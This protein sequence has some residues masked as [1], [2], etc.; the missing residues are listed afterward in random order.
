[1]FPDPQKSSAIRDALAELLLDVLKKGAAVEN[2]EGELVRVT[3]P[4]SYLAVAKDYIKSFPP[5][6]IPTT[7]SPTGELGAFAAKFKEG[8]P[9]KPAVSSK[10]Q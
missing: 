7:A 10:A 2:S 1:M 8:L 6:D 3:P 9:F 5:L 4:A